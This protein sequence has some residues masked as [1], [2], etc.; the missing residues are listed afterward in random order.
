MKQVQFLACL[1]LAFLGA[2][3]SVFGDG[4]YFLRVQELGTAVDLAQSRQEV[5]LAI[6]QNGQGNLQVTYVFRS[7]YTGNPEEF[8][9]ILPLP[10]TPTDVV[11]HEDS[12][13]FDFLD[14]LTT[15]RF[16]V[17]TPPTGN[18]SCGCS[19]DTGPLPGQRGLINVEA[20]GEAGI[21]QWTALTSTGGEALLTWLN[22]NGFAVPESA[23]GLLDQYIAQDMHFLAL[24]VRKP[25]LSNLG[26][27][28]EREIPP[29]QVTCETT[30]WMY[31]MAISQ[32][33]AAN[34]TDVLVYLF[35]DDRMEAANVPNGEVDPEQLIPDAS[36]PSGTNYESLFTQRIRG[37]GSPALITEYAQDLYGW[38]QYDVDWPDAPAGISREH[39]YL[40]RMRTVIAPAEMTLDF[41]FQTSQPPGDVSPQF[42]IEESAGAELARVAA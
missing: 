34:E 4:A 24:R 40:T 25:E 20:Q 17:W 32:I 31:P 27:A 38:N 7:R 18:F 14:E 23:T 29:I 35:A 11:A 19:G 2:V 15:P 30:T 3:S 12:K 42:L 37:L 10:A 22:D 33:S 36:S 6:H 26:T 16:S 39:I 21:F 1:M 13:L 8:A 5:V 9:W 28:A 41:E